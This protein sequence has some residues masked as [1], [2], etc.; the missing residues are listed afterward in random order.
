M[1][2]AVIGF[3]TALP[4]LIKIYKSLTKLFGD[5]LNKVSADLEAQAALIEKSN[6]LGVTL[7]QKREIR[8]EALKLG[9][10]MF[11]RID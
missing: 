2:T 11:G 1:L 5:D 6:A 7:E 9:L 8:R 10:G 3:F 4:D